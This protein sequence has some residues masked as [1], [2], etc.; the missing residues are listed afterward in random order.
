MTPAYRTG[1]FH[2]ST[3]DSAWAL[4]NWN[5]TDIGVYGAKRDKWVS[6]LGERMG[7]LMRYSHGY[8]AV[9]VDN[10]AIQ[11][12]NGYASPAEFQAPLFESK[13]LEAGMH[14][15]LI[16]NQNQYGEK[17]DPNIKCE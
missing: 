5:G 4:V 16:V 9:I 3:E 6:S 1:T 10:G 15:L 2:S 11:Y 17:P 8:Y 14:Q 13:D 7:V 12:F